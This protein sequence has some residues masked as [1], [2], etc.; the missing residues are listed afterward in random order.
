[1]NSEPSSQRNAETKTLPCA[2]ALV[3][4]QPNLREMRSSHCLHFQVLQAVVLR[5]PQLCQHADQEL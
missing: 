5:L 2:Y 4:F 1:M 3:V